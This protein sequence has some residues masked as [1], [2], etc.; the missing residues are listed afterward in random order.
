MLPHCRFTV[1][2]VLHHFRKV[3]VVAARGVGVLHQFMRGCA[4]GHLCHQ[5]SQRILAI[6]GRLLG[7]A[8]L[9]VLGKLAYLCLAPL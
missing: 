1:L 8:V 3:V 7:L 2:V 6:L 5:S 9:L 4:L